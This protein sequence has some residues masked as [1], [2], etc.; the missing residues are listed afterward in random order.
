MQQYQGALQA[1]EAQVNNAQ[2]AADVTRRSSAPIAGRLGLRQ[3]DAGN[4]IRSGD[5]NGLVVITQMQPISVLFTVPEAD[6]PAV[7]EACRRGQPAA[8]AGVGPR[9]DAS[10]SPKARSRRS[11]TRST[12]PPGTIKLRARVRERTRSSCFRTSS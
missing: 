12:P 4:L 7:L 11:T 8:G 10:C 2:A 5:A 1:N 6:L 3:V 9:R